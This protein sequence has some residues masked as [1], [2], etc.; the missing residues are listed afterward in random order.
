MTRTYTKEQLDALTEDYIEHGAAI[1]Y[2]RGFFWVRERVEAATCFSSA[3]S[4]AEEIS[5]LIDFEGGAGVG[6]ILF[7]FTMLNTDPRFFAE[8]DSEG[9]AEINGAEYR[10]YSWNLTGNAARR[11]VYGQKRIA[12]FRAGWYVM[13]LIITAVFVGAS[14]LISYLLRNKKNKIVFEEEKLD[15]NG[16]E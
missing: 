14:L 4:L 7:L 16:Q 12:P 1:T 15:E 6:E 11:I 2:P 8:A 9:R 13:L 3:G 10:S 5:E